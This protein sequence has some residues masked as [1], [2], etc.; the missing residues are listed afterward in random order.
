M[1]PTPINKKPI[2]SANSKDRSNR[3][4]NFGSENATEASSHGKRK[5]SSKMSA[6]GISQDQDNDDDYDCDMDDKD[7]DRANV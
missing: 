7:A 3:Q 6:F 2:D 4:F 1:V 5:E